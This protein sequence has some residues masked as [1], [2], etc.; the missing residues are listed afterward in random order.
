MRHCG[1]SYSCFLTRTCKLPYL[2]FLHIHTGIIRET[3]SVCNLDV[4]LLQLIGQII[5]HLSERENEWERKLEMKENWMKAGFVDGEPPRIV[6]NQRQHTLPLIH[7]SIHSNLLP[8]WRSPCIPISLEH[9]WKSFLQESHWA[10]DKTWLQ[11]ALL[12]TDFIHP[13]PWMLLK[14]GPVHCI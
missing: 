12:P 1:L 3:L 8:I 11:P 10:L 13:C 5:P 7:V 14:N 6:P 9:S 2:Q 4:C